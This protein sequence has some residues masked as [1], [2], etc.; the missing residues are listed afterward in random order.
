MVLPVPTK[1]TLPWGH[2]PEYVYLCENETTLPWG[3]WPEYVYLHE[4]ETTLPWGHWPE[5]VY[6]CEN[7]GHD[8]GLST[9]PWLWIDTFMLYSTRWIVVGRK[10]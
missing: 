5:Y 2:W 6:L 9:K 4:N 3:H 7:E 8:S 10:D 1:A